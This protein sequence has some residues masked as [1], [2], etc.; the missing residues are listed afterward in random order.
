MAS[1]FIRDVFETGKH[2][3][4]YLER[5]LDAAGWACL[6]L[7]SHYA[8]ADFAWLS[9]H[10]PPKRVAG[11]RKTLYDLLHSWWDGRLQRQ[12]ADL[13]HA[14]DIPFLLIDD[15]IGMDRSGT[16]TSHNYPVYRDPGRKTGPVPYSAYLS[17][18]MELTGKRPDG[19]KFDL[20]LGPGNPKYTIWLLTKYLPEK[21]DQEVWSGWTRME[22]IA[23]HSDPAVQ[24]LLGTPGIGVQ[25]IQ[26]LLKAFGNDPYAV[27]TAARQGL[28]VDKKRK[29]I[30]PGVG[31]VIQEKMQKVWGCESP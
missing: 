24:A 7:E 21:Y 31:P 3:N 9:A 1:G 10:S 23:H 2:N 11:Q 29:G 30:V 26:D 17:I 28:L 16:L 4:A 19:V 18:I 6:S 13:V 14:V 27:V 15:V 25:K 22:R 5:G 8:G 12:M 20:V